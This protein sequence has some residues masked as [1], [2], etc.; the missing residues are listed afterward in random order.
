MKLIYKDVLADIA[1]LFDELYKIVRTIKDEFVDE[2]KQHPALTIKIVNYHLEIVKKYRDSYQN[3]YLDTRWTVE[4]N[5]KYTKED[6][7][8]FYREFEN[9][10]VGSQKWYQKINDL[11]SQLSEKSGLLD[12]ILQQ[13]YE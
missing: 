6:L 12:L 7:R 8:S 13:N 4:K 3:N 5:I 2:N 11:M 1:T 10:F 9:P